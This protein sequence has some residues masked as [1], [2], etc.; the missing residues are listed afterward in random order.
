MKTAAEI[1]SEIAA[2]LNQ[3]ELLKKELTKAEINDKKEAR[4]AILA[5]LAQ[6]GLSPEAVFS[7]LP[8]PATR[9]P[10][11]TPQV[12]YRGPNGQLWMG[13]GPHPAWLKESGKDKKEF[14]Q[15]G[16]MPRAA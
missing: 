11:A 8:T 12:H 16:P 14:E 9:A 3:I 4:A 6:H 7:A 2:L 15:P 5:I 10:A 1:R 13:R